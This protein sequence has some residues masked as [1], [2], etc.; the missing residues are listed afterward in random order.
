MSCLTKYFAEKEVVI[1][2]STD[3]YYKVYEKGNLFHS[4]RA[5]LHFKSLMSQFAFL[6]TW[7]EHPRRYFTDAEC[8]KI[9]ETYSVRCMHA[10]FVKIRDV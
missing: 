4:M 1:S 10:V 3:L 7:L 6:E 5:L 9:G 8:P 2:N